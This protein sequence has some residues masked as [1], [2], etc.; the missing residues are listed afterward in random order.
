MS[1]KDRM[2]LTPVDLATRSLRARYLTSWTLGF[3]EG[4]IDSFPLTTPP[5]VLAFSEAIPQEIDGGQIMPVSG[6]IL[7][8]R[9]ALLLIEGVRDTLDAT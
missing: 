2:I 3:P 8:S 7:G 1:L 4:W 5:Q 6:E 9:F